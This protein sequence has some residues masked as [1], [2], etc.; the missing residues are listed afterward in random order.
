MG[1]P[2]FAGVVPPNSVGDTTVGRDTITAGGGAAGP[3]A[4]G[5]PIGPST[6]FFFLS[7]KK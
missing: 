5:A 6:F 3:A 1:G 4:V 7:S 2:F